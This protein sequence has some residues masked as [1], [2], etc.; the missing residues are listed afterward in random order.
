MP[1]S[2]LI[3]APA[4]HLT[5]GAGERGLCRLILQKTFAC[6]RLIVCALGLPPCAV[7][8]SILRSFRYID[9]QKN[10]AFFDLEKAGID[11]KFVPYTVGIGQCG[12]AGHDGA[13]E[14]AVV[15]EK[16]A[17]SIRRRHGETDALTTVKRA[18]GGEDLKMKSIHTVSCLCLSVRSR[19]SSI[20]PALKKAD[21]GQSSMLPE[22]I[23]RK[24]RSVS[25]RGT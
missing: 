25:C 11:K 15:R 4:A 7:G 5:D 21:S 20:V 13:D 6:K 18:V 17:Q 19:T 14:I 16:A 1:L 8:F 10:V 23:A 3:L 22:R 24:P 2:G 9:E 12:S